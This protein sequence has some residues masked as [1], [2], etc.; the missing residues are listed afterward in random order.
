MAF[1]WLEKLKMTSNYKV[2]DDIC[3]GVDQ[4]SLKSRVS[5][6]HITE[7][8]VDLTD[9]EEIAP[10]LGLA[11][12][13]VME[14][15][16]DHPLKPECQRHKALR[17]WQWKNGVN[18][19]YEAII[20]ILCSPQV[21]QV[22]LAERVIKMLTSPD[23]FKEG[24]RRHVTMYRK[25]LID[26][27][28]DVQHPSRDQWPTMSSDISQRCEVYVDLELHESPWSELSTKKPSESLPKTVSFG[29]IFGGRKEGQREV[30]VF[31]GVAGSGK[32]TLCWYLRREWAK[33]HLLQQFHLLIH[34]HLND[35][36]LQSATTLADFIVNAEKKEREE[37]TL[38][39][40]DRKGEGVCFLLDGL[41]EASPSLLNCVFDHIK[42]RYRVRLSN[43]SF[44]M[45]TRPN[46]RI[47]AEMKQVIESR[48]IVMGGFEIPKLHEFMDLCLE[49]LPSKKQIIHEKFTA[50]PTIEHLCTLP[51]NAIIMI[52][53]VGD[54]VSSNK[55]DVYHFILSNFLIRHM[56]LRTD[57]K[58]FSQISKV[59]DLNS[60]PSQ[61]KD[62]FKQMCLLA[63]S[64]TVEGI[65]PLFTATELGI[66]PQE[67]VDNSLG[68]LWIHRKI[69]MM[70]EK[71][72]YSFSCHSLRDYLAAIHVLNMSSHDRISAQNGL[73]PSVLELIK[74]SS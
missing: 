2:A 26:T 72:Y 37:V 23:E 66:P 73:P 48:R 22:T 21:Q 59:T 12:A 60:L 55:A 19:T 1:S 70:G 67:K 11:D 74:L 28:E 53:T 52:Q 10:F 56:R 7:I 41:E 5:D 39:I 33:E 49:S 18:A 38:Y 29:D 47:M 6:F 3:K 64:A 14:I 15:K 4:K 20:R 35:P 13:E 25:Q 63:Y 57:Q 16:E 68:L 8:A 65:S 69:T 43:L 62:P 45:T 9:W 24:S 58:A 71:Q 30:I 44:I 27:F 61:I 40:L 32:T 42:G 50:Y 54:S 51:V 46:S 34:I 31:E 36:Q 17:T